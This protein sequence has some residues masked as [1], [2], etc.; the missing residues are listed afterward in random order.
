[1]VL[2]SVA[3]DQVLN[4]GLN[5]SQYMRLIVLVKNLGTWLKELVNDI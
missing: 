5:Y 3:M 4:Q 1:M 2:A